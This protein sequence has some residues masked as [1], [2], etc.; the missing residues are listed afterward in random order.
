MS[1]NAPSTQLPGRRAWVEGD[2]WGA[3]PSPPWP[4][5]I[6]MQYRARIRASHRDS[7]S[8]TM[9][10][11]SDE[12]ASAQEPKLTTKVP[13]IHFSAADKEL[14]E[15]GKYAD[16]KIVANGQTYNV[17][18]IVLCTRSMWF[19]KAFEGAFRVSELPWKL[20]FALCLCYV[21]SCLS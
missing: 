12:N 14:L 7:P 16:A 2:L 19:R 21:P 1:S 11:P 17:H 18:K 9:A 10:T 3:T 4:E 20:L 6:T 8:S 5:D 13:A 15:S